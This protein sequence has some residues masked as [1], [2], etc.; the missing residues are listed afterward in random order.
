MYIGLSTIFL[1]PRTQ[2]AADPYDPVLNATV[3][4]WNAV[5]MPFTPAWWTPP[6]FYPSRDIA[7]FTENLAGLGPIATPIFWIT[8]DAILTYNLTWFL[9]WPLSA[10]GAYVL[11]R[12]V[13]GRFDAALVAGIAFGFAPYRLTQIG[14]I[15]VLAAFWLPLALAALHQ[16]RDTHRVR[17]LAVFGVAWILQSLSNGYFMLFGGILIALWMAYFA[18]GWRRKHPALVPMLSAW[19]LATLPLLAVMLQYRAVHARYGLHR[20]LADITGLGAPLSAWLGV[21]NL[22]GLWSR[23]LPDRGGELNLFP[24]LTALLLLLVAAGAAAFTAGRWDVRRRW[25]QRSPMLFYA[26]ATLLLAVLACGPELRD[27]SRTLAAW[28]PYRILFD[29]VPGFDGL[30][31]PA[32]IWMMGALC[33]SV[34]AACAFAWLVP[35]AGRIRVLAAAVVCAAITAEGWPARVPTATAPG[36]WAPEVTAGAAHAIVE[37]PFRHR[38]ATSAMFRAIGHRRPVV[39]GASGYDPPHYAMLQDAVRDRDPAAFDALTA[40]G[41]LDVLVDGWDD[42]NGDVAGFVAAYPGATLLGRDGKASWFRLPAK[43]TPA[44]AGS[45]LPIV[46]VDASADVSTVQRMVDGRT[47]SY[48]IDGPQRPGQWITVDLG[49]VHAVTA[50]DQSLGPDVLTYPRGFAVDGSRDGSAWE[51]LW[52]GPTLGLLLTGIMADPADVRLRVGFPARDVRY[53]RLRQTGAFPGGWAVAE[54]HVFAAV[55]AR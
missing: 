14:H 21:T 9:T 12:K 11:A 32:R 3:L 19:V 45:P 37:L 5:V 54:I 31:V 2:I 8:R 26:M 35:H 23:W 55:E 39:N 30:R 43:T 16:Y 4:W 53:V 46:A 49:R 10:I 48:W 7:A 22:A 20:T 25:R 50:V 29:Y 24:G 52:E 18:A 6:F 17:W 40:F 34:A 44:A 41:P 28:M 42:P 1:A 27:G 15:Q 13:T 33:L 36:L 51:T 47:D 38:R